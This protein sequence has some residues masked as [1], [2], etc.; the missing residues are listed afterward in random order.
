MKS[1]YHNL[2]IDKDN[3]IHVKLDK[4]APDFK[5]MFQTTGAAIGPDEVLGFIKPSK[6]KVPIVDRTQLPDL[7]DST[8]L[9]TLHYYTSRKLTKGTHAKR[10]IQS[11]DETALL[12][13]GMI[14]EDWADEMIDD[15]TAK[16]FMEKEQAAT[17]KSEQL[18][19]MVKFV[20]QDENEIEEEDEDEDEEEGDGEDGDSAKSTEDEDIEDGFDDESHDSDNINNE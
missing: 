16:L 17:S 13:L 18:L 9:S 6:I 7:P 19:D 11:M 20:N 2:K 10:H 8:L 3:K 14:V 1:P 12:A 15:N 5:E 4:D